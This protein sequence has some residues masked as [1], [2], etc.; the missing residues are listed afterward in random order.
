[1][2]ALL[3]TPLAVVA[4]S[5]TGV[6]TVLKMLEEMVVKGR[7]GIEEEK[8]VYKQ[9]E[10]EVNAR[11][12]E[13]EISIKR[14]SELIEKF[15]ARK[16][17]ATARAEDLDGT[18]AEKEA[19]NQAIQAQLDK[20]IAIRAEEK[21]VFQASEAD[22]ATAVNQIGRAIGVLKSGSVTLNAEF[23]QKLAEASAPIA[24][25]LQQPQASKTAYESKSTDVI[26]LCKEM[27][28]KLK[29]DLSDLRTGEANAA[30]AHAVA[31]SAMENDIKVN[32]RSISD[33]SIESGEKKEAAGVAAKSEV[34]ARSDL[35][36][37]Q[38]LLADTKA[39]WAEQTNMFEANSKYR[40]EELSALSEAIQII[41]S[42][43][44]LKLLQ[45]PTAARSLLQVNTMTKTD[46]E[47][48]TRRKQLLS[49]INTK[50][51]EANM[52]L[53]KSTRASALSLVSAQ[54]MSGSPFDKIIKM[55][56]DLVAKLEADASAEEAHHQWCKEELKTTD[57]A[58]TKTQKEYDALIRTQEK[59]TA[60]RS[61]AKEEE[62]EAREEAKTLQEE[63]AHAEKDRAAE[64]AEN[65]KTIASATAAQK[66]VSSAIEVLK[67][68]YGSQEGES[69]LQQPTIK[70]YGGQ[71]DSS[72]GVVGLMETILS[73][74][75]Q[76]EGETR[77]AETTAETEHRR[78]V[79][80]SKK[81]IVAKLDLA[82]EK[83][84]VQIE[85]TGALN[86]L[87]KKIDVKA[88]E[89]GQVSKYWDEL[90]PMCV[91]KQMSYEE[92]VEKRQAEIDAL[93]EAYKVLEAEANK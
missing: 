64:K 62:T 25:L 15:E 44:A 6:Q 23:M 65:E 57:E 86:S 2:R 88:K 92:R 14:Q 27:E 8:A 21:K 75:A 49:Q 72:G 66:A 38:A 45:M 81:T 42:E 3:L 69:L 55:L 35:A 32:E 53:H 46:E 91:P 52:R 85:K 19:Q 29:K 9:I 71:G 31:K 87:K 59:L 60:E 89:L 79:K 4:S 41:D 24:A 10:K 5:N 67:T 7:D 28:D 26:A 61:Q 83:K 33:M 84:L 18:I 47:Q 82:S 90:Q 74:F 48:S 56:E 1:M 13:A 80:H 12:T 58:K 77:S 20:E 34:Q 11:A 22:L 39:F 50:L 78:F 54:I 36:D 43:S 73:D 51:L 37:A 17:A 76:L 68:F 40:Q 63:M 30:N 93:Q 16:E 70:S